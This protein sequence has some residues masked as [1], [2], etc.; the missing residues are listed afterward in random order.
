MSR[1]LAICGPL[2]GPL[3]FSH[4]CIGNQKMAPQRPSQ[5]LFGVTDIF[6]EGIS[7]A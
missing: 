4:I 6:S 5:R 7:H 2:S 1:A 3:G